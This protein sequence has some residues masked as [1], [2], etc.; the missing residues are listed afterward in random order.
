VQSPTKV[1]GTSFFTKFKQTIFVTKQKFLESIGDAQGSID[2]ETQHRIDKLRTTANDYTNLNK[3][4]NKMYYDLRDFAETQKQLGNHLYEIGV[5]EEEGIRHALQETGSL[6]R[7]L[8]KETVSLLKSLSALIETIKT[9]RSAAVEDTLVNLDRYTITRQEYDGAIS[10]IDNLSTETNPDPE[11]VTEVKKLA[12][13]KK[14]L[15]EKLSQDLTTKIE[16]LNQKRVQLLETQLKSYMQALKEY[17]A[18][19]A[20]ILL[21]FELSPKTEG[22]THE[23]AELLGVDS[24][25]T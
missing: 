21:E 19:C 11:E 22:A 20:N 10:W 12:E 24:K 13:D 3:L 1:D 9:F 6:H 4:A 2:P 17:Y 14:Q 25:I 16:I 7:N 5:K 15:M 18:R 8:E 23:F